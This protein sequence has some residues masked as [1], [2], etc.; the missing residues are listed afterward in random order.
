VVIE[1]S[2]HRHHRGWWCS[3]TVLVVVREVL[4]VAVEIKKIHLGQMTR[5]FGLF[6]LSLAIF[7]P[8][9]YFV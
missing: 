6:S 2:G 4:V 9:M 8:K 5:H 7:D 1:K 3:K